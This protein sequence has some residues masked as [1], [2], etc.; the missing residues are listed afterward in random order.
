[1]N[2]IT[3]SAY[4]YI[5]NISGINYVSNKTCLCCHSMASPTND[6]YSFNDDN[7]AWSNLCL[8]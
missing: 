5:Y 1:M 3:C 6:S 8:M 7:G 4:M 2:I